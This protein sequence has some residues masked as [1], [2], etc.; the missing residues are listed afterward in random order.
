MFKIFTTDDLEEG[1]L[2]RNSNELRKKR[3]TRYDG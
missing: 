3:G 2:Q 1:M